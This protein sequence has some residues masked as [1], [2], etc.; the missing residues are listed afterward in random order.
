MRKSDVFFTFMGINAALVCLML[1]HSHAGMKTELGAIEAQTQLVRELELTDLCLLT[2]ARYTR[3]PTQAD[4]HAPFQDHPMSLE[5][6]PT[7][8]LIGP[9]KHMKKKTNAH[10]D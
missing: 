8:S 1:F 10:L 5:H 6:F 3:H 7:G 9:P 2:E 4:R